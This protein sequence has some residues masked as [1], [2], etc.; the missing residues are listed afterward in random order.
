MQSFLQEIIVVSILT[1]VVE[2]KNGF[3][4]YFGGKPTRFMN[5][6]DVGSKK[7]QE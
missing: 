1:E 5:A 6:V 3:G 2:L 4:I 7:N